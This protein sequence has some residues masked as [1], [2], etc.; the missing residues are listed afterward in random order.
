MASRLML[1]SSPGNPY[2]FFPFT[3]NQSETMYNNLYGQGNCVDQIKTCATTGDNTICSAA[4]TYC[5]NKV[6]SLYDIY[7]GRDEYDIRELTPD[8]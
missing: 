2:D 7:L 1:Y 3:A 6:E 5:A 4:D 8:P